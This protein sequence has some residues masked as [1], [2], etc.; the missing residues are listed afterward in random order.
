[1]SDS[2]RLQSHYQT[3]ERVIGFTRVA[4][5]KAAPLLVLQTAV[6]GLIIAQVPS[7]HAIFKNGL[8]GA[9][10]IAVAVLL[11]VYVL[12]AILGWA[13]AALVYVPRC[14]PAK[15]SLIYFEDIAKMDYD[16][17][18]AN[19]VLLDPAGIEE[20]LLDQIHRVSKIAS[21]KFCL[22]RNS[23]I[24]SAASLAFAGALLGLALS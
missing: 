13:F 24:S 7:F 11:G 9:E 23:F 6:A 14:P 10:A 20:Q 8:H 5:T 18:R 12:S 15:G 16:A 4:D 2:L 17:F 3:L 1:M 19:S 21:W 22:V